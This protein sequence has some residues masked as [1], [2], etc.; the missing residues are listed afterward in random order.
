ML[1]FYLAPTWIRKKFA[2]IKDNEQDLPPFQAND[3]YKILLTYLAHYKRPL[4]GALFFYKISWARIKSPYVA[5][6]PSYF[7]LTI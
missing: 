4:L 5:D 3:A 1:V 2:K 7:G 6:F